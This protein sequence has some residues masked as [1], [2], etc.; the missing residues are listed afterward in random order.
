MNHLT[1]DTAKRVVA[2]WLEEQT[3]PS[4]VARDVPP[5]DLER[6]REI[7]AI[8]G[9]RRAG[10]TFYMY[11]L[12][13][14]LLRNGKRTKEDILFIDFEDYRL[15]DFTAKDVESLFV[16]FNQLTGKH[17]AFVFFDEIQHLK[18]W[19]R[20]IRT[21]HNQRRY[22]VVVSGSNSELLS[23]EI[24]T[25]LRGRYR[26]ILMLPFSF[27]EVLQFRE[28]AYSDRTLLTPARGRVLKAFDEYLAEGGF[29]EVL[30]KP[31]A[32][33]KKQLLQTY[34]R[35]IYYKDIVERYNI[36]AK[37][38]LEAMMRYCLDVYADLFS[39]STFAGH[40][41]TNGL[42][43]SKKTISNYLQYMREAFFLIVNDKFSYSPRK[44]LMNPK[45][46]YL[47]D[48]GFSFLSTEFSENKGKILENAV[49]IELFRRQE[50]AFYHKGKQECDFVVKQGTKPTQAIQV[51]WTLNER[52]QDRELN[53]LME[54][55]TE[56]GIKR[57]MILTYDQETTLHHKGCSISVLPVWKW[58]LGGEA[59]AT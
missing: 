39:I 45:K 27:K 40:L 22:R 7:L 2:E 42:P 56:F 34:Y 3:I 59:S 18:G 58:M 23:T 25:E 48:V 5:V 57:G 35:T 6:T 29:P 44:R 13:Q 43:G 8:V 53:G 33:E 28:I 52:S 1:T 30:N 14:E 51:C 15:A 11:Q 50:E 37:Y 9:P 32:L 26:D 36:K 12:M 17:P 49:A 21:L 24:S 47:L 55:M 20:V 10:K 4:L 46:V 41:K 16:A 19:S 38:V 31:T 54:A